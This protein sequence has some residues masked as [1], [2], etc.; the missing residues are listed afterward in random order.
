MSREVYTD[1]KVLSGEINTKYYIIGEEHF[2]FTID[3]YGTLRWYQNGKWHRVDGP[4]YISKDGNQIWYQN[5]KYHRVDGPAVIDEY[6]NWAWYQNG[7]CHRVGGPA[8]INK[9][10][11]QSWYVYDIETTKEKIEFL[12]RKY[13]HRW[14]SKMNFKI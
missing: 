12:R 4:A 14:L 3:R 7:K 10:G 9:D 2:Y 6:G 13:Y 5:G 11:S 8:I 1:K